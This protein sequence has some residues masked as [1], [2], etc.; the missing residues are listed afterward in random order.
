MVALAFMMP[1]VWNSPRPGARPVVILSAVV[2]VAALP[3]FLW[4]AIRP[5]TLLVTPTAVK[6]RGVWLCWSDVERVTTSSHGAPHLVLEVSVLARERVQSDFVGTR[7][8]TGLRDDRYVDRPH[9]P[10]LGLYSHV[11]ETAAWLDSVRARAAVEPP[12][13]PHGHAQ[14]TP[15]R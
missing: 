3:L 11:T 12:P 15:V 10:V 2:V 4:F 6:I 7:L 1:V 9:V 8:E 5:S 14:K 13:S